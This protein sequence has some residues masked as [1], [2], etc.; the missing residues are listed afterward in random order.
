MLRLGIFQLPLIDLVKRTGRHLSEGLGRLIVI[1]GSNTQI[2]RVLILTLRQLPLIPLGMN[3]MILGQ[4]TIITMSLLLMPVG[5]DQVD[6]VEKV[7]TLSIHNKAL[8]K[9]F[10]KN[11]MIGC[12]H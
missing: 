10:V 2:T 11:K 7:S 12:S 3:I 6:R 8:L 1:I 4:K 5:L 9:L